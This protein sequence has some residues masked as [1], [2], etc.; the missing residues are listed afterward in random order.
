MNQTMFR[1]ENRPPLWITLFA[2]GGTWGV[3]A[4][5]LITVSI[6]AFG[7]TTPYRSGQPSVHLQPVD[8]SGWRLTT[9]G[10][11][12]NIDIDSQ[13][14]KILRGEQS[15]FL[16]WPY[17]VNMPAAVE[18]TLR[19]ISGSNSAESGIWWQAFGSD[20]RTILAF[21]PDGYLGLFQTSGS[22]TEVILD[23]HEFPHI[24]GQRYPNHV[25]MDIRDSGISLRLNDELATEN[26]PAVFRSFA[27]GL[28]F[29]AAGTSQ[30]EIDLLDIWQTP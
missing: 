6:I 11:S 15:Y 19:Q 5:I 12:S 2:Y 29:Y 25:R 23:W 22:G 7:L 20:R 4:V 16:T 17:T 24:V 18:M 9:T 14:I 28:Y 10:D 8:I 1:K 30:F 3:C 26:I 13:T 21:K 27:F